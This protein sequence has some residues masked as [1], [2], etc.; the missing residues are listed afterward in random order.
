MEPVGDA[1]DEFEALE[2]VLR[3]CHGGEAHRDDARA[4]PPC[5]DEHP[6]DKGEGEREGRQAHGGE[7]G[8]QGARHDDRGSCPESCQ[9]R[10]FPRRYVEHAPEGDGH[11]DRVV[12]IEPRLEELSLHP[13]GEPY[14]QLHDAAAEGRQ[15]GDRRPHEDGKQE[16]RA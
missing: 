14:G 7:E 13:E 8:R 1:A 3:D 15:S 10:G 4:R 9:R 2:V 11:E 6:R 5:Q 12:A 16:E